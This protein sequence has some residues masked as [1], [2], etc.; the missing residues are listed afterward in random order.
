MLGRILIN[1]SLMVGAL[2]LLL[3]GVACSSEYAMKSA[4]SPSWSSLDPAPGDAPPLTNAPSATQQSAEKPDNNRVLSESE[5]KSTVTIVEKTLPKADPEPEEVLVSPPQEIAGAFLTCQKT[6]AIIKCTLIHPSGEKIN[7]PAPPQTSFTVKIADSVNETQVIATYDGSNAMWHWILSSDA[8]EI[9]RVTNV[10]LSI[11]STILGSATK[12]FM[13]SFSLEPL[14]VGDGTARPTQG[15]CNGSMWLN[16]VGKGSVYDVP[17]IIPPGKSSLHIKMV[18][19]CGIHPRRSDTSITLMQGGSVIGRKFIPGSDTPRDFITI[20]ND[21]A[22][23]SYTLRIAS[24]TNPD[25]DDF[26]FYD[27]NLS[28]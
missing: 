15:G 1:L 22:P 25:I 26:L 14:W 6:A 23:G 21:L 7:F 9:G 24:G 4:G 13:T 19:I 2:S 3:T 12:A 11:K 16:A 18:G 5:N 17:A 10:Q 20:W 8:V 28:H 27:I